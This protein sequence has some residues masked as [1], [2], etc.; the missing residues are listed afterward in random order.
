MSAARTQASGS[1]E[2]E[3]HCKA[4]LRWHPKWQATPS[5]QWE[6]A[7]PEGVPV[8][9]AL[10]H[11]GWAP[12]LGLGQGHPSLLIAL[13]NQKLLQDLSGPLRNSPRRLG[14]NRHQDD[15]AAA[16]QPGRASLA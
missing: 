15:P 10:G 1:P 16:G 3:S 8:A 11:P 7:Q 6:A 14:R 13:E 2:A 12:V 5:A 9:R 4:P